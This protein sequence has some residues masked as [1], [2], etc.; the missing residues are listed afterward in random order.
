M[1]ANSIK[2]ISTTCT[3]WSTLDIGVVLTE[4]NDEN[5]KFVMAYVSKS[6]NNVVVQ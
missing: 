3:K 4:M 1:A 2:A 5:K 6:N